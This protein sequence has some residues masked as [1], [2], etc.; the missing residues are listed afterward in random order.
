MRENNIGIKSLPKTQ[1]EKGKAGATEITEDLRKLIDM[2]ALGQMN[3]SLRSQASST[4]EQRAQLE[5][6]YDHDL[7]ITEV[8]EWK[9]VEQEKE[10]RGE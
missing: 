5:V 6:G 10:E 1:A 2:L 9:K 3:T 4:R 7:E 8:T